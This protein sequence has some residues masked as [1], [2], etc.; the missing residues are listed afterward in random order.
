MAPLHVILGQE[1]RIVEANVNALN[2]FVGFPSW[3]TRSLVCVWMGRNGCGGG[4]ALQGVL[5]LHQAE[6]LNLTWHL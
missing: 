2:A 4:K 6:I 3:M 5:A 1:K